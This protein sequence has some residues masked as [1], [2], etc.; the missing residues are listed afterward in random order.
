MPEHEIIVDHLV[1]KFDAM[2]AI[3]DVSFNVEPGELFAFLGPNGAG[4]TTTINVLVTILKPTTG[5]A[6]VNGFDVVT[7]QSQVRQS[8]GIVFQDPSLDDRLSGWQNLHFHSLVYNM[9]SADSTKR[10]EQLKE[11]TTI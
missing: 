5:K 6:L 4:K 9:S 11:I 3:N 7:Q 2:A 10:I 1:K 8:I